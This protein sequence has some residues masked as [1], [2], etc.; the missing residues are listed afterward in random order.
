[1]LTLNDTALLRQACYVDG[2]WED[3][4]GDAIVVTNPATGAVVGQVPKLGRER[5]Q[6]AIAA[7]S[8]ALA[9][10]A[11]TPAKERAGIIRRWY[12]LIVANADDLARIL[13]AEQGKPFPEARG[14][15]LYGAAFFEWFAEEAKRVSGETI[16]APTR[17]K[18][19]LAIRQPIGV[20]AAI[21]PWNFPMAMI[22]RKA[23][24]AIAAGCTMVL[25]PASATP[26]SALALAE[27]ADRAGLPAGVFNVVTGSASVVG[28][29]L[30]TNPTVRKVTFTGSTEVG[31]ELMA[32][33]AGTIKKVS[34]ELG[35]NA[36]LIVFDDATLETA[37]QGAVASKFRN[38]GQTCVC[39]NR[40][41]VQDGIYDAFV[42]RF[43]EVVAAMKV[44]DG[45][46]EGSE[47]GPLIDES[48]VAKVEEHVA[49]ALAK[50]ARVV[51]GGE[52]HALGGTFYKPTVL[53]DAT[54]DMRIAREE[55]FGPV[56]PVFRFTDE[57]EVIA[58]ANDTEFGLAA[59]FFTTNLARTWRV[60]EALEFGIVGVNAG[61]TA[62]EGAPFG[63]VKASGIGRE[64]SRHGIEEF[65]EL[66]YI[67]LGDMN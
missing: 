25:K 39:A 53:A 14:E 26:F 2:R 59:Y 17:D 6:A 66:K 48:A 58:Q 63:G 49:D 4:T 18:R 44:G 7:A 31:R 51:T 19:L 40:L 56:A 32:K 55:T 20:C 62:Y 16:P 43:A 24:P 8:A 1:M 33:A 9:D 10:W 52:R 37:V 46:A 57:K 21:T 38:A 47:Q 28:D 22:P 13:T 23:G 41:Y 15:I 45:M 11:A 64:G 3:G 65:L 42:A 27:L 35:G 67:C 50:G 5:T 61:L 29:E 30:V 36:P 34:L 54:A 12:D 60:A